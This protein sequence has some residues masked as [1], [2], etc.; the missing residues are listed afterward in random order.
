MTFL[1]GVWNY[2]VSIAPTVLE[3]AC[4]LVERASKTVTF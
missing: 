2:L 3:T 1:I 4:D